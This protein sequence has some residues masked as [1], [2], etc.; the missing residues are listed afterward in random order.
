M[1]GALRAIA[2]MSQYNETE[3]DFYDGCSSIAIMP[4]VKCKLNDC[5]N[6]GI[7]NCTAKRVGVDGVGQVECYDPVP[8]SALIHKPVPNGRRIKVFK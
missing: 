5:K 2:E 1:V 7:E 8:K 4:T 3:Y 6:H